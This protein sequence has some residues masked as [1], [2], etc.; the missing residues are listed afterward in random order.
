MIAG[1]LDGE[2]SHLRALAAYNHAPGWL[3]LVTMGVAKRRC[4]CP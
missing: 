3:G 2:K 1:G 4:P